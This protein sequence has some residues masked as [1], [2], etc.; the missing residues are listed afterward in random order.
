MHKTVAT[1]Y[2]DDYLPSRSQFDLGAVN[3]ILHIASLKKDQNS[4]FEV[5]IALLINLKYGFY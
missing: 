1:Q 3:I 5:L 4:R 2:T